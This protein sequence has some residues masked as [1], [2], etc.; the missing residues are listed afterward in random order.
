MENDFE[1]IL[2]VCVVGLLAFILY[3]ALMRACIVLLP[4][5]KT[6]IA[7]TPLYSVCAYRMR[8]RF[9]D[10]YEDHIKVLGY[11]VRLNIPV[12]DLIT[13]LDWVETSTTL[14]AIREQFYVSMTWMEGG[15]RCY[16][17]IDLS[18]PDRYPSI[19]F[20]TPKDSAPLH[21]TLKNILKQK[22]KKS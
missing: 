17:V 9:V 22:N 13:V 15:G 18:S 7:P 2:W 11:P 10:I 8:G 12:T 5:T 14:S 16:N 21:V 20:T 1:I 6:E 19:S 3:Y 4:P